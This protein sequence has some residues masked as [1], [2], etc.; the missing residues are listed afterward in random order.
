ML[1][2]WALVGEGLGSIGEIENQWTIGQYLDAHAYLA[3]KADKE[4][5]MMQDAKQKG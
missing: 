1:A 2:N 5:A 4:K 3:I